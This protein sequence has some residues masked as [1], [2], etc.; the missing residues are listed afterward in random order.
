MA[1]QILLDPDT[2]LTRDQ[3]AVALTEAG[4]PVRSAT[5][6]TK[7]C[8]GG[9]PEFKLFGTRPLYRWGDALAWAQAKLTAPRRKAD[10]FEATAV[11]FR[12]LADNGL[13]AAQFSHR[14][15]S[16]AER[17]VMGKIR[18]WCSIGGARLACTAS[19]QRWDS[20]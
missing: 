3:T 4:F 16:G 5:L 12:V 13:A 1:N 9:G 8:R 11:C 15:H 6:A 10:Q 7:A 14:N 20:V 2:L 19:T 18:P 17:R